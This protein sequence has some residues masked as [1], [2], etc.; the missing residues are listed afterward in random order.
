MR[1]RRSVRWSRNTWLRIT[2]WRR[3]LRPYPRPRGICRGLSGFAFTRSLICPRTSAPDF[4]VASRVMTESEHHTAQ[5]REKTR[6]F[7]SGKMYLKFTRYDCKVQTKSV[8]CSIIP[9]RSGRTEWIDRGNIRRHL[10]DIDAT[11]ASA[12]THC[13]P[14]CGSCTAGVSV[15][16][17]AAWP[18]I[19]PRGRRGGARPARELPGLRLCCAVPFPGQ[20]DRFPEADRLRYMRILDRATRWRRSLRVMTALLPAPR[21]VYGGAVGRRRGMVR[22]R[23]G[24][25]RYTW[26]YARRCK[27]ERINLWC[28]GQQELF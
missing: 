27:A 8:T 21:R 23:Q 15:C 22:R 4:G 14:S 16:F 20:A 1:R 24:G 26:D 11:T 25:T 5:H 6:T 3:L 10:P 13:V 28:D 2:F 18:W 12:T 19:R 17:G 7:H 9:A